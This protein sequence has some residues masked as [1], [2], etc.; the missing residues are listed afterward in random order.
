[1]PGVSIDGGM[2]LPL[3]IDPY[4]LLALGYPNTPLFT[5][6]LGVLDLEGRASASINLPPGL[7][8]SL[9][10]LTLHHAYVVLAFPGPTLAFASNAVP[11]T[12]I[13]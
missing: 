9:A 6:S 4:Y 13:P 5:N 2:T 12:L 8:P 1:M 7:D 3:N 11:L 10:G